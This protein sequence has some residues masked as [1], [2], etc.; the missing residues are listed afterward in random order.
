[1][2]KRYIKHKTE[3][4]SK[5]KQINGEHHVKNMIKILDNKFEINTFINREGRSDV[6]SLKPIV[7]YCSKFKFNY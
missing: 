7:D 3:H 5:T 2:R 1:M 4:H 6:V